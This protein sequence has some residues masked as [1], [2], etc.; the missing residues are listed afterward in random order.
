MEVRSGGKG[1]QPSFG[2]T[3][4]GQR[5]EVAFQP[6]WPAHTA[7]E[8]SDGGKKQCKGAGAAN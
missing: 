1:W 2:R 3:E 6:E 7:A 8:S 4:R 5:A